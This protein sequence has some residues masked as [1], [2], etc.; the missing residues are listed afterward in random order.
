MMAAK[1]KPKPGN[2]HDFTLGGG[3]LHGEV[4]SVDGDTVTLK[5]TTSEMT[6]TVPAAD[7]GAESGAGWFA[8][9]EQVA[10]DRAAR[11]DQKDGS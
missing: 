6:L 7:V 3:T 5:S 10:A 2:I 1:K 11:L 9:H 4:V 8:L